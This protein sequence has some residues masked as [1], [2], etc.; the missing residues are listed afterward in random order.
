MSTYP[1][2]VICAGVS[3]N[4]DSFLGGFII[5]I[6]TFHGVSLLLTAWELPDFMFPISQRFLEPFVCLALVSKLALEVNFVSG[7]FFFCFSCLCFSF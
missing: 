3:G 4:N 7:G 1:V 2:S 6:F 5:S